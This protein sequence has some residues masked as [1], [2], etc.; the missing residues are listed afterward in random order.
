MVNYIA[1][2][3]SGFKMEDSELAKQLADK[4]Q[5]LELRKWLSSHGISRPRGAG[6]LQS[7]KSAVEQNKELVLQ[8]LGL[9]DEPHIVM[10]KCGFEEV[11]DGETT[12]AVRVAKEHSIQCNYMAKAWESMGDKGLL[13]GDRKY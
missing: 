2:V 5:V 12:D 1:Q 8:E 7:A 9:I 10:C 11:V 13:Y 4:F 6:K 3:V